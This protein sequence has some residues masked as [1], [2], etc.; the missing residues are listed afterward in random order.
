MRGVRAGTQ[1]E[2]ETQPT[3]EHCLLI[4]YTGLVNL[5]CYTPQA[6]VPTD[7]SITVAGALLYQV[8]MTKML[9]DIGTS[10]C[11]LNNSS[12]DVPLL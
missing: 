3:E 7:G 9:T 10:Q 8:T 4:C 6:Q 1:T 12:V 11:G 2:T 5:Y